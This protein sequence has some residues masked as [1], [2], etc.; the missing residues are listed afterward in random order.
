MVSVHLTLIKC[1]LSTVFIMAMV[2]PIFVLFMNGSSS[3][4]AVPCVIA[5]LP[6]RS[7]KVYKHLF[8]SLHQEA[9]QL[10][11][12]FQPDVVM[13]DFEPGLI[14]AVNQE[15]C[16]WSS[17]LDQYHLLILPHFVLVSFGYSRGMLLASL[18]SHPEED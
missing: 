9:K 6:G 5:L 11:L 12:R 18:P 15:V 17:L 3:F 2:R 16:F 13:T 1:S 7:A 14:N 8:Q 10:R 4:S